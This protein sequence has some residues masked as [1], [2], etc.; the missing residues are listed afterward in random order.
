MES[1]VQ[2]GRVNEAGD[3]RAWHNLASKPSAP[4]SLPSSGIFHLCLG[5]KGQNWIDKTL[6]KLSAAGCS[7]MEALHRIR[8]ESARSVSDIMCLVMPTGSAGIRVLR[9]F[10]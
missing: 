1:A 10:A 3:Q 9:T 6:V 2:A 5:H 4:F 7:G 8:R